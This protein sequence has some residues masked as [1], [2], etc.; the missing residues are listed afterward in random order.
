[1]VWRDEAADSGRLGSSDSPVRGKA[2]TV[3]NTFNV[4]DTLAAQ[5]ANGG[6]NETDKAV[7]GPLWQQK[8]T[9]GSRGTDC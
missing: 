1:M 5:N 9:H 2:L 3:M 7:G 8:Q 4:P 6:W